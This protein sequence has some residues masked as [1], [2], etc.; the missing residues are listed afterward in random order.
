MK[1]WL[2][3]IFSLIVFLRHPLEA[4]SNSAKSYYRSPGLSMIL[5]F[6]FPGGGQFYCEEYFKGTLF[7]VSEG[8]LGYYIYKSQ[9]NYKLT[10]EQK[11]RDQRNN[12]LWWLATVKAISLADAYISAQMYKFN[13]QLQLG[14]SATSDKRLSFFVRIK[15]FI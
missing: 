1:R 9:Q 8:F 5:S 4:Y 15:K 11:Y 10:G 14:L 7:L 3:A 12:L 2:I 13:E 6:A